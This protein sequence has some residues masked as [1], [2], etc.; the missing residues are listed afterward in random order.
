MKRLVKTKDLMWAVAAVIFGVC[1]SVGLLYLVVMAIREWSMDPVSNP[2]PRR[3][4]L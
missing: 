2:K 1:G 3:E 4:T